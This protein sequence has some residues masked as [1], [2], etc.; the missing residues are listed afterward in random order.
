MGLPHSGSLLSMST[1]NVAVPKN[2]ATVH[3]ETVVL[4]KSDSSRRVHTCSWAL[5]TL[6][7]DAVGYPS[8]KPDGRN[9]KQ[10]PGFEP[11]G[12]NMLGKDDWP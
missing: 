9:G 1:R 7:S 12:M 5:R 2:Q 3:K 6:D 11:G 10:I 8:V 4:T